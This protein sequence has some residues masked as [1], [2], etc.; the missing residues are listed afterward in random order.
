MTSELNDIDVEV[1]QK[2]LSDLHI[3]PK[4]YMELRGD[5]IEV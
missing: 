3:R 5:K 1:F 2:A 4:S